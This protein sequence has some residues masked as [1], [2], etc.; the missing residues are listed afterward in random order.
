MAK[1]RKTGGR[2]AGTPNKATADLRELAGVYTKEAV[3]VLVTVM[4]GSPIPAARVAAANS[5]L[6]RSHGKPAQAVMV[7]GDPANST[8]IR[9]II[10]Q[11]IAD[12]EPDNS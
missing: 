9:Q 2:V 6:D 8:P 10:H 1:G 12:A 4:R 3:L 11:Y 7:A 5:L